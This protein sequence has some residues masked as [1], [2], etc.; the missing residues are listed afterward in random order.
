LTAPSRAK[1]AA[2]GVRS[3]PVADASPTQTPNL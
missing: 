1:S 2:R 3:M